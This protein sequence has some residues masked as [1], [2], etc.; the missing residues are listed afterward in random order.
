MKIV[1]LGNQDL[2]KKEYEIRLTK[3]SFLKLANKNNN[4]IHLVFKKVQIFSLK[5]VL[6]KKIH[7]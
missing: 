2:V 1:K 4:S 6:A 5:N 7:S 3:N